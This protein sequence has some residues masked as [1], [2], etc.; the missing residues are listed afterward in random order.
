M[1]Q[2]MTFR[3]SM[4]YARG[5]PDLG[6]GGRTVGD[7]LMRYASDVR[8][9]AI[10][11]LGP[12]LGSVTGF[13]CLAVKH[14]GADVPI[15]VFDKWHVNDHYKTRAMQYHGIE[16]EGPDD[17]VDIYKE[18][19]APFGVDV[20]MHRGSIY[21]AEWDGSP[22]SLYINDAGS[23]KRPTDHTFQLFSPSFIPGVT[24]VFMM[25]MFFFSTNE[26]GFRYQKDFMNRNKSV[27]QFISH[28]PRSM[29]GIYRYLGGEIDYDVPEDV[30][31]RE[32]QDL[33][34]AEG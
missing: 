25:D 22:I 16:I 27:F 11:E 23:M 7:Q 6:Y 30:S 21:K 4:N 26:E 15:H 19:I 14:S 13:L 34:G 28:P 5:I 29:C 17:L 24:I 3:Q 1:I 32:L 9:G 20:H 2:G 10:V 31:K 12:W 18:N 8:E 33:A